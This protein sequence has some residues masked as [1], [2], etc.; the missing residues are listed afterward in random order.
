MSLGQIA[1]MIHQ[2]VAQYFSHLIFALTIS[3]ILTKM[4]DAPWHQI[5]FTSQVKI[6]VN[7]NQCSKVRYPINEEIKTNYDDIV[8]FNKLASIL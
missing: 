6:I 4:C 1:N 2:S 8:F 3:L 7:M 5:I